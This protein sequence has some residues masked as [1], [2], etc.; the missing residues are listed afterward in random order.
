MRL[1]AQV[2]GRDKADLAVSRVHDRRVK[3]STRPA[4]SHTTMRMPREAWSG[5]GSERI[6]RTPTLL[7]AD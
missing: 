2:E 5:E 3:Q 6:A 4:C 1:C 7:F